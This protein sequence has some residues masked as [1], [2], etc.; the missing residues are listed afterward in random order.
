M[1]IRILKQGLFDTLQDEGRY[2]YQHLGINPGGAMDTVAASVANILVGNELNESVIE[3]HFPAPVILFEKETVI[4]I[5]GADFTP[6]INKKNVP[7][8]QPIAVVKNTELQFEQKVSGARS[9]LSFLHNI[10]LD[11]WL[12][13]YSTNLTASAGGFKGRA[14]KKGDLLDFKSDFKNPHLSGEKD[15][16]LLPWRST[17][18]ISLKKEIGFVKGTVRLWTICSRRGCRWRFRS[19][20]IWCLRRWG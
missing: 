16:V 12:S 14:L 2:G 19:G 5:T 4:C 3:M 18:S 1:S 7:L 11:K 8:N 9:Y 17:E 10:D 20:F 6:K 13:S 15:F